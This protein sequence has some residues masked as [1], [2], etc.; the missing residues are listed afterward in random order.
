[1][2]KR[3]AVLVLVLGLAVTSTAIGQVVGDVS[4]RVLRVDPMAQVVILDNNQTF[5]VTPNTVLLVDNRPVSLGALQPGQTVVVRSGETVTVTPSSP[6]P[7]AGSTVVVAPPAAPAAPHQTTYGRVTDVDSGEVKIQ[8]DKD[9]FEVRVPREVA[10]QIR[11]GD[12]VRLDLTFNP[13]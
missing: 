13:R 11:K 4:G 7:A 9:K 12:T 1:M 3:I 10:A 5:R 2:R 8:T 6:P